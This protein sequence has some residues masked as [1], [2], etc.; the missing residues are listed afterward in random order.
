VVHHCSIERQVVA[1]EASQV[2]SG[3]AGGRR[4]A[5]REQKEAVVGAWQPTYLAPETR[6]TVGSVPWLRS[7]R[8]P[9]GLG[10]VLLQQCVSQAGRSG[11]RWCSYTPL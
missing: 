4:L 9:W 1:Y 6:A 10:P 7:N 3:L 8:H 11:G 2:R 5:A